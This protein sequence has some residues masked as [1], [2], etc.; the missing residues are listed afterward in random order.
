MNKNPHFRVGSEFI[1]LKDGQ[2][3]RWKSYDESA[4]LYEYALPDG[5]IGQV[6]RQDTEIPS[7]NEVAEYLRSKQSQP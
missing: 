6:H 1:K 4:G 3:Y 2:L 5:T 7:N